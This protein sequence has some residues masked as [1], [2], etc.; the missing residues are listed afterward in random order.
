MRLLARSFAAKWKNLL[1]K[2]ESARLGIFRFISIIT[3]S[4]FGDASA[5]VEGVQ[6]NSAGDRRIDFME[7]K[8]VKKSKST[9]R[10]AVDLATDTFCG[11]HQIKS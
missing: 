8:A 4:I 2:C 6:F 1:V 7:S 5:V 9:C 10:D 11:D 3:I